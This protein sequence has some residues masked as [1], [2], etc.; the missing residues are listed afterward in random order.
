MNTHL[1]R[2][3]LLLLLTL[4]V[5][6]LSA[7]DSEKKRLAISL[8][9]PAERG[10][11][12]VSQINGSITVE[13]YEGD[14]VI[15]EAETPA[16][17]DEKSK[18]APPGMKRISSN[19]VRMNA[20]QDDNVVEVSTESWKRR[21]DLDIK[22]PR[23]F[24]LQ[25]HTVHG[26]IEVTG[27]NGELEISGVNGGIT[28]AGIEGSAVCNTVNGGVNVTM[29]KVTP[30]VPMSFVTLNGNVDVTLPASVKAEAKMRSDQGEIFSDFDMVISTSESTAKPVLAG[31]DE[32]EV[33]INEWTIGKI[34]GGGIEYTFK[35]LNGDILIRKGG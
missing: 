30:D 23:N 8:A 11:L 25:L 7:Q 5:F 28:L 15:I 17:K 14:E 9:D 18:P 3:T 20:R 27:V 4:S 22:V 16:V 32:Y 2:N 10:R 29:V 13:G 24:D 12:E 19:P 34:N 6:G 33:S 26:V 1:F 35:N 21:M 31:S